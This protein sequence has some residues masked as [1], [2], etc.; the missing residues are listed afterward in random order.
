MYFVRVDLD[1]GIICI[2]SGMAHGKYALC[3]ISTVPIFIFDSI[4]I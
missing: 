1:S 4:G 3:P 2:M